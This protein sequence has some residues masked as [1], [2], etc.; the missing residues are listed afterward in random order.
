MK[1]LNRYRPS[2]VILLYIAIL[3]VTASVSVIKLFAAPPTTTY[4]P[5]ETLTPSCAPGDTNCSV[6]VPWAASSGNSY[7]NLSGNVGIGTTSPY[8]ALSVVGQVVGSYFTSTST[9]ATSTF[10]HA[11]RSTCF[12]VDGTSCLASGSGVSSLNGL[13]GSTQTFTDV[14]DTNVTLAIGSS[15]STHTLTMGWSGTLA[16]ARGGLGQ[17]F[18]AGNGWLNVANGT[19]TAS[20]SPTVNWLV[21]TSTTATSTLPNILARNVTIGAVATSPLLSIYSDLNTDSTIDATGSLFVNAAGGQIQMI[22]ETDSQGPSMFLG[23]ASYGWSLFYQNTASISPDPSLIDGQDGDGANGGDVYVRAGDALSGNKL[24]GTLHLTGGDGF[25][26]QVGGDIEVFAGASVNGGTGGNVTLRGGQG[27]L[28]SGAVIVTSNLGIGTTTPYAPLSV[29]GQA[30][31]SYFTA[32]TSTASVFPYASSTALTVSG[33]TY[34]G[35]L[36]GPL[37][38][39]NGLVSA[40]STLSVG[41]GGTGLSTRPSY[42]NILVGTAAGGYS[43][44]ATSSLG[45]TSSQWNTTASNIYYTTGNVGIGTS[46]PQYPLDVNGNMRLVNGVIYAPEIRSSDDGLAGR[47]VLADEDVMVHQDF[48]VFGGTS[49][50][51]TIYDENGADRLNVHSSNVGI[52]TT[53]P[54]APLSVVGQ[55]VGSYFTAT[56]TTASTFPYASSTAATI[57]GTLYVGS[58]NGPLQANNGTVS[59]TTSVGVLYG[60]TGLTTAPSYGQLLVGNA[61]SGYTL[62]ATSSL[63]IALSDTVGTLSVAKGGTGVSS[64]PSYGQLLVG[65]ASSGYTLTATSSLKIALSDTVGILSVAKG[66][67]G[68]D[69]SA[70]TGWLNVTNGTFTAS[71]SPTVNW[72]VATSTTATS[73]IAG[74]LNIS[75]ALAVGTA[76]PDSRAKLHVSGGQLVVGDPTTVA[77]DY[78]IA[79]TGTTRVRINSSGEISADKYFDSAN[80]SYY[81]DPRSGSNL[82]VNLSVTSAAATDQLFNLVGHA[83]QSGDYINVQKTGSTAGSLLNFTAAGR[84]G[85]GTSTP[86]APLS[87][88][89]QVVAAN[90]TA[91]TT[92]TSTFIGAVGVGTTTPQGKLE[93]GYNNS[94][95]FRVD[96]VNGIYSLGGGPGALTGVVIGNGNTDFLQVDT[97]AHHIG[98]AASTINFNGETTVEAGLNLLGNVVMTNGGQIGFDTDSFKNIGEDTGGNYSGSL[99]AVDGTQYL[100]AGHQAQLVM[101][102]PSGTGDGWQIID[103]ANTNL[104]ELLGSGD[105][106]IKNSLAIGTSTVVSGRVLSTNGTVYHQGLS[107]S[108][109]GDK[110]LCLSGSKEVTTNNAVTCTVSSRRYKHDIEDL[111]VGLADINAFRPVSF[112]YNNTDELHLGLIAE[113]VQQVDPRL[114]FYE[115]DGVTPRGVN[116]E[117][118]TAVLVKGMQEQQGQIDG[119][120]RLL[121]GGG[122]PASLTVPSSAVSEL[123]H[124]G[125]LIVD[126]IAT[127]N[128]HIAVASDVAGRVTVLSGQTEAR[129]VFARPYEHQPVVNLTLRSASR[130]SWYRVKSEDLTGFTVEIAETQSQPVEFNW[131]AVAGID[132][133][134][135]I[136]PTNSIPTTVTPAVPVPESAPPPVIETTPSSEPPVVE[137]VVV[138][139]EP[140]SAVAVTEVSAPDTSTPA[141]PTHDEAPPAE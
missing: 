40:T 29:V 134:P 23:N 82:A 125:S 64:T 47:I 135:A 121:A 62:T 46:D 79:G 100:V 76:A 68:L 11:I 36:T 128:S 83:S 74:G 124:T 109:N 90:F 103:D 58:L 108:T 119:L 120:A 15:G 19:F 28:R 57:S 50:T 80:S 14:D 107:A 91:T 53:T 16:V 32:T 111:N 54:Y 115:N 52:G 33:S 132:L 20:T 141:T 37:Q 99:A 61:S 105:T 18:A 102:L 104:F 127:F 4:S 66:G 63:N 71:T 9:T 22:G 117:D 89:G 97:V 70:A 85:I 101:K 10:A 140:V 81:I 86:Y 114:V 129:V 123:I 45:I 26:T 51:F 5:G 133:P 92:A 110:A 59:A 12:S 122:G 35:S 17:S 96:P 8:A 21:A 42:G 6:A 116:Y 56:T 55:V 88:V 49:N 136:A 43:L 1:S 69:L 87:V 65:N 130:L 131:F 126:G 72:F 48:T 77:G 139:P 138:A 84:L 94:T 38:A 98:F 27:T 7:F 2:V 44:T 39:V 3:L 13:T 31:A 106:Y 112:R 93:V 67:T 118:L 95:Y 137:E 24:G 30:V 73:S 34:L 60:G 75:G 113:E 41:Y 78:F 25:G